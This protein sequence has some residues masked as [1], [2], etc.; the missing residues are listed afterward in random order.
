MTTPPSS[1]SAAPDAV[2]P[3]PGPFDILLGEVDL[4][5]GEWRQLVADEPW[6]T[7]PHTRLID[8]FPEV[9]P[10]LFRLARAGCAE[11]DVEVRRL[12]ADAHGTPRRQDGLPL[13]AVADEW[14][15]LQRACWAVLGRHG[16]PEPVARDAMARL[17]VLIDDAIGVTLR[18]YYAP[19]LDALRGRG[20]ERRASDEDRRS[21]ETDRRE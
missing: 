17:E 10:K 2:A 4:V 12:V 16:I 18:G 5:L 20:L 8:S 21:G 11:L 13:R 19:E 3:A 6:N 1:E 9:L 7:I 15:L 14:T